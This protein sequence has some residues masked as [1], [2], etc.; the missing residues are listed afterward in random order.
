MEKINETKSWVFEK[1]GKIDK[2]RELVRKKRRYKLPTSGMLKVTSLQ[3][4]L[5]LKR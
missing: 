2:L 4:V 5:V 1:S 3:A